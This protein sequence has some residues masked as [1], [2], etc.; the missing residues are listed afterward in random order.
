MNPWFHLPLSFPE[1]SGLSLGCIASSVLI[2][3][4]EIKDTGELR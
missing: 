1:T 4:I 2:Q 3:K